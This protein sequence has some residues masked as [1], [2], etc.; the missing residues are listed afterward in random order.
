VPVLDAETN[1]AGFVLCDASLAGRTLDIW[2]PKDPSLLSGAFFAYLPGAN[3]RV[4]AR[5]ELGGSGAPPGAKR[6]GTFL[7]K[8]PSGGLVWSSPEMLAHA[9]PPGRLAIAP[10]DYRLEVHDLPEVPADDVLP[11]SA[12]ERLFNRIAPIGCL[13]TLAAAAGA[14][15]YAAAHEWRTVALLAGGIVA[16]W[17]GVLAVY[18]FGPVKKRERLREARQPPSLLFCLEPVDAT[19]ATELRGGLVSA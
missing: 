10:G 3:C 6:C 4:R 18:N 7:L 13:A 8:V 15:L 19:Q 17:A 16:W 9:P 1:V 2:D 5:V 14:A 11:R 12:G